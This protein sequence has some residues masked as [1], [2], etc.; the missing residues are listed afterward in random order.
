MIELTFLKELMLIRQANQKVQYLPLFY[1][2]MKFLSFKHMH[3]IAV[4]NFF[5]LL[6]LESGFLSVAYLTVTN[7]ASLKSWFIVRSQLSRSIQSGS[8]SSAGLQ[9]VTQSIHLSKD[10]YPQLVSNPHR[11]EIQPPKQLDYSCLPLHPAKNLS[12]ITILEIKNTDYCS[13]INRNSKSGAI[14][15]FQNIDSKQ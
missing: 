6:Y 7:L 1:F 14:K 11:S 13:I 5:Q 12:N 2:F 8:S 15:L 3:A 4:K 9:V 10:C